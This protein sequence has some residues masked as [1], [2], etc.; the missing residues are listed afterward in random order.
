MMMAQPEL[1]P[2][3]SLSFLLFLI[4]NFFVILIPPSSKPPT[5]S[6][7]IRFSLSNPKT[8]HIISHNMHQKRRKTWFWSHHFG[9]FLR[10]LHEIRAERFALPPLCL[11]SV[12]NHRWAVNMH[13]T[14]ISIEILHYFPLSLMKM[15][16]HFSIL[17]LSHLFSSSDDV[18]QPNRMT[19]QEFRINP[20]DMLLS[21]TTRITT[22]ITLSNTTR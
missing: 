11:N 20:M 22:P 16:I 8:T 15:K 2:S 1:T 14:K 13:H 4:S 17:S 12:L 18:L 21:L 6:R 5:I 7:F 9:L 19:K 3:I 10:L